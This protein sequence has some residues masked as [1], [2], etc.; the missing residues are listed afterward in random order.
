MRAPGR[1]SEENNALCSSEAGDPRC[2]SVFSVCG[3]RVI[4]WKDCL[5]SMR[6]FCLSQ[7]VKEELLERCF[8]CRQTLVNVV[9]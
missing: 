7:G 2:L 5:H 4:G 1:G 6:T 9:F 8:N 3:I